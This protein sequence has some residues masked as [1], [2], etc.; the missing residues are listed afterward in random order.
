[1]PTMLDRLL[2]GKIVLP[3]WFKPSTAEDHRK[4]ELHWKQKIGTPPVICIDN[5][6]EYLYAVSP[7][8]IWDLQ[9]DFPNV[10]PPFPEFWIETVRPSQ[11]RSGDTIKEATYPK[12][13]G[14]HFDAQDKSSWKQSAFND[15]R[16]EAAR[17]EVIARLEEFLLRENPKFSERIRGKTR[18]AVER[19]YN[20]DQFRKSLD[21]SE[22]YIYQ[23]NLALHEF[24]SKGEQVGSALSELPDDGWMVTASL[25]WDDPRTGFC[26]PITIIGFEVSADGKMGPRLQYFTPSRTGQAV[27]DSLNEAGGFLWSALLA[28][29]FMHC[30]NVKVETHEPDAKHARAWVKQ[31]RHPLTRYHTLIIDPMREVLRREGGAERVGL[32]KALHICRG[33]FRT[34]TEEKPMF[35]RYVGTVWTPSHVRGTTEAGQVVKDYRVKAPAVA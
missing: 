11:I 20:S 22:F 30:R 34:Y 27:P 19:G 17:N 16:D 18:I 2:A 3:P 10:A 9:S 32:Q 28:L 14:W 5:V 24:R 8:E 4:S 23:C 15:I 25:F 35:G 13:W 12:R 6:T 29:S 7:K 31:H 33:H 1:M 21:D 26:G